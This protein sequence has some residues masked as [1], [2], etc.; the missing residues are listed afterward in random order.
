MAFTLS[1]SLAPVLAEARRRNAPFVAVHWEAGRPQ[2]RE[3]PVKD[4]L[5]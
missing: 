4:F 1:L 5:H 3:L 2:R